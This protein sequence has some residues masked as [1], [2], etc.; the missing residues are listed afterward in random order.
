MVGAAHTQYYGQLVV[1]V[2]AGRL[3]VPAQEDGGRKVF[4][5][6]QLGLP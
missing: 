5:P 1:A 6:I 4:G 3:G 2:A